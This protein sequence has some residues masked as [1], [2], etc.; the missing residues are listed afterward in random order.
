MLECPPDLWVGG[1]K[2]AYAHSANAAG[3]RHDLVEHLRGVAA[4]ARQ[5]ASAFGAGEA[6]SY[7]GLWH[8]LGSA[9]EGVQL[10]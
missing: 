3:L 4:L 10:K 7:A 2:M 1:D 9:Y 6:A 8:D 5:F